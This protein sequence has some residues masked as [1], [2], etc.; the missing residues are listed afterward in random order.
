M[1]VRSKRETE[2]TWKAFDQRSKFK[3]GTKVK[4]VTDYCP[5]KSSISQGQ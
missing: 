4:T 1:R 3:V 5:P 2:R